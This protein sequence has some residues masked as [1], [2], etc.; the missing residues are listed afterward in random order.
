MWEP[1]SSYYRWYN[2]GLVDTLAAQNH[3]ATER[4]LDPGLETLTRDPTE[5]L[6]DNLNSQFRLY[7]NYIVK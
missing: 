3:K 1:F 2:Q 4:W 7:N 5:R 6:N